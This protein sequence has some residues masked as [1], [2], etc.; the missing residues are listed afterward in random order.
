MSSHELEQFLRAWEREA[1]GTIRLLKALPVDHYDARP[2]P[3][4]RSLGELAW[5]LAEVEAYMTHGVEIGKFELGRKPPNIERPRT[6]EALAP[7]YERIH[8]EAVAR[9]EKL[10]PE[11]LDR[12]IVFFGGHEMQIRTILWNAILHHLIHHRG[13]LVLMCRIAG[14]VPP[15]LYGPT[16]EETAAFRGQG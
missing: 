11:D 14:G 9:I 16:R 1:Q 3:D 15:G 12:R 5:H 2:D 8:R 7:G 10:A 13:E 6:V 4:G